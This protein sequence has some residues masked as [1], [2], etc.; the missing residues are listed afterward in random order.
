[1]LF[2]EPNRIT[3]KN[4]AQRFRE[5]RG[6]G[7]AA[8]KD[9]QT[10]AALLFYKFRFGKNFFLTLTFYGAH[11]LVIQENGKVGQS[12]LGAPPANPKKRRT[13]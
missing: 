6:I 4:L 12:P 13:L 3:A 2:R 5:A 10:R 7:S 1:M 8:L 11:N 9:Y